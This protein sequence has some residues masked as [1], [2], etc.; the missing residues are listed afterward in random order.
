MTIVAFWP[1]DISID[2]SGPERIADRMDDDLDLDAGL[3]NPTVAR[4]V[5]IS[6]PEK[7]FGMLERMAVPTDDIC[8]GGKYRGKIIAFAC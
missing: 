6:L 2:L 1:L 3:E 8:A 5:A 4:D 7:N